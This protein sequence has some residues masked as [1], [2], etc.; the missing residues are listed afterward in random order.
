MS[1]KL[2]H[3]LTILLLL[4][5]ITPTVVKLL[6]SAFHHHYYFYFSGKQG[7]VVHEYHHTCPIPGFTLTFF[8]VQ[9]Q[10]HITH[11]DSYLSEIF[12]PLPPKPFPPE[13]NPSVLLRAPPLSELSHQNQDCNK[14]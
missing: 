7:D 9:K 4:V 6:D 8:S 13:T 2:K 1:K 3:I 14:S 11:K 12:I 10:I 5:F